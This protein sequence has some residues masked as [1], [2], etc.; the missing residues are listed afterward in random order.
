L[1]QERTWTLGELLDWTATFLAQK[2]AEFPRLDA[3]VLLAHV[4]NCK[5]IQLYTRYTEPATPEQRQEYRTL[6]GKRVEGCPVAYLVGRKEFFSLEL[7]VTPAVLI[8]RPDSEHVVMECVRVA[9][10]LPEPTILDLGTGSGNL[11]VAIAHRLPTARVTAVDLSPAALEV[12]QR[13][14][15]R[16]GVAARVTFLPG[17]LFAP[18]SADQ[19]YAVIVSNPPYS[20][21]DAIAGLAPGCRSNAPHLALDGGRGGFAILSR[22]PREAPA[23]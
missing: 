16:H 1:S 2:G 20:P 15:E 18:L 22:L 9:A 11:A 13:N 5:R 12:A 6:I 14:A 3:E 8:P 19:R 21:H 10:T 7:T 23:F 17:D 4:L